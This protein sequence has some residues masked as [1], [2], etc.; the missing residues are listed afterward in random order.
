MD[1]VMAR[2][3]KPGSTEVKSTGFGTSTAPASKRWNHTSKC[4]WAYCQLR[5]FCLGHS[6]QNEI[7][8]KIVEITM[9]G[10]IRHLIKDIMRICKEAGVKNQASY[11]I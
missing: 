10:E 6:E 5:F 7:S 4:P 9:S 2:M 8:S 3:S 1:T 11:Q